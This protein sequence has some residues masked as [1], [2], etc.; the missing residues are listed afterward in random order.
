MIDLGGRN[1]KIA[2][3]KTSILENLANK[4][5]LLSTCQD[6]Q[7]IVYPLIDAIGTPQNKI[8]N[9]KMR[10]RNAVEV[11]GIDAVKDPI[12]IQKGV[13]FYVNSDINDFRQYTVRG[14]TKY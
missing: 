1:F 7:K 12:S 13:D 4:K 6:N 3:A 9:V 2:D 8:T 5:S 14:L 10:G 11:F